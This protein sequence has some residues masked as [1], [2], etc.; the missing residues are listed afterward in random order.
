[1]K[2]RVDSCELFR[3]GAI[4]RRSVEGPR[5]SKQVSH[6]RSK[7]RN[8]RR[9]QQHESSWPTHNSLGRGGQR[10]FT[11]IWELGSK[12]S[13]GHRL[14]GDIQDH[15]GKDATEQ[16]TWNRTPRVADFAAR[17][18]C[19]LGTSESE[20]Q[21]QGGGAKMARRRKLYDHQVFELNGENTDGYEEE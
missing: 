14:K 16:A 18:D 9:G 20:K 4:S 1:M 13:L 7:G 2:A 17:I 15:H 11:E 10:R 12:D 19:A 3:Q 5:R 6:Q 21:H 8:R